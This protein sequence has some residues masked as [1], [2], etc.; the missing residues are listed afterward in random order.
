MCNN[1]SLH[2]GLLVSVAILGRALQVRLGRINPFKN[3]GSGY[4]TRR[5][6]SVD[7]LGGLERIKEN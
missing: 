3:Y 1:I 6:A 2:T 5:V 7:G 4:M